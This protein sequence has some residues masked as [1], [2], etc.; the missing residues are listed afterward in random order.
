MTLG[1]TEKCLFERPQ[2]ECWGGGGWTPELADPIFFRD[3]ILGSTLCGTF[4]LSVF[5]SL[6]L[7]NIFKCNSTA[8]RFVLFFH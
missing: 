7:V 6:Q 4:L 8:L 5:L 2:D 3:K 1:C